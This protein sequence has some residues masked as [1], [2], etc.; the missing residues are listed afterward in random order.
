MTDG[1]RLMTAVSLPKSGG[2]AWPVMLERTPY[3]RPANDAGWNELGIVYVV[4]SVR[5]RYGSEGD[6]RP[7]ADEGWGEH[8]DGADTVKWILSQPWCNGKIGTYGG[9]APGL[10]S[11]LLGPASKQLSCQVIQEAC[12][13]FPRYLSYEGGVFHKSLVEGWL[14]VGVQVPDYAAVWKAE[15]PS[16]R[17]WRQYDAD[18]V[19]RRI[20]SP[21]LLVGGWWDIFASGTIDTFLSRQYR[22]GKG[23]KGNQML[24]MRP[25]AHGPWG[26]QDL[27]FPPNYDEFRI[28]PYRRKFVQRW[29]TGIDNGI[30][31]DPA[32][33]YYTV[34]D[35][36]FFSGPGWEWRTADTWPPFPDPPAKWYLRSDGM[37]SPDKP[38]AKNDKRAYAFDPARPVPTVGGAN[39][40]IDY[41]PLDQRKVGPRPDVLA[42]RSASCEAPLEVTG[43]V[44]VEL[45]VS[46]DA[47]D[48]DFTAKL[49]DVYPAEDGREILM[50]DSITRLRYRKG[51]D[52]PSGPMKP[53]K[54]VKVTV[55]LG[56]ISWIFNTGHRVG[57]D[58]SS[59]NYP[60]FD[61]NPNDGR[62][63]LTSDAPARTARNEV[64]MER[65]HASALVLPIRGGTVA[66]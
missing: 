19:A 17:Y 45:Y 48:T 58:V 29:L 18:R 41:G 38:T 13:S 1:V 36:C 34:G 22:G 2:P 47:P 30:G 9:S 46:T 63:F 51:Y 42:F 53:G 35:D 23:A 32:V 59:S 20:T 25:A 52:K 50:L 44:V 54:I 55:D 31:A 11:A 57:L 49:M 7:F 5:G 60:R 56:N 43:H 12:G 33:R 8:R 6:F 27:K 4:Q 64:L 62:E 16:S 37:L 65:A 40:V 28:T 10:T 21:G 39:L 14:A 3:P 15:P 26:K 24:I 61:V 66:P